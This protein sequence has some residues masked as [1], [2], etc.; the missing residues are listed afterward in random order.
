MTRGRG[1][2]ISSRSGDSSGNFLQSGEE[3]REM[4]GGDEELSVE[5]FG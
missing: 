2:P 3:A 1:A 5:G 4:R